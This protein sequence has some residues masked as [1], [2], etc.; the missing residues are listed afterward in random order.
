M[1]AEGALRA[2][3]ATGRTAGKLV[4]SNLADLGRQMAMLNESMEAAGRNTKSVLKEIQRDKTSADLTAY[5]NLMLSPGELP[6]PVAPFQTPIAEYLDPR[7]LSDADFGP[8]PVM[9]ARFSPSAASSQAWASGIAGIAGSA[10]TFATKLW[11]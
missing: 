2:T 1:Q 11:G 5:A 9:G 10:G 6:M 7:P 4:Q 3:G 8:P